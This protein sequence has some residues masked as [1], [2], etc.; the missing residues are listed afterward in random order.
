MIKPIG[1]IKFKACQE[2]LSSFIF[3]LEHIK[4]PF[5][6]QGKPSKILVV[7][8]GKL[9]TNPYKIDK[10]EFMPIGYNTFEQTIFGN[11]DFVLNASV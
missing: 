3:T 6:A 1:I 4:S 5:V 11:R 10:E 7:S 2:N 9:F 8:Y